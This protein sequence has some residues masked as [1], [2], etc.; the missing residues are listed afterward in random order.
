MQ[1][2]SLSAGTIVKVIVI[3]VLAWTLWLL[4]E[5]VL[6]VLASVVLASA[7]EPFARA[8]R[9]WRVAR[10]PAVIFIYLALA[11]VVV[12]IFYFFVPPLVSD[13]VELLSGLPLLVNSL[14][15]WSPFSTLSAPGAT[16]GLI[17]DGSVLRG[18]FAFGD[19]IQGL[20]IVSANVSEGFLPTLSVFFGGAISFVLIIVISFYLAVQEDGIAK[21]LRIVTPLRYEAYALGLWRRVQDKIGKWMQGQLLLAVLVGLL[22]Y[23]GLTVLGIENA[24]AFAFLAAVLETIPLFGP[25]IAAIPAVFAAYVAGGIPTGLLVV[26]LYVIIQQFENHLFYPLVVKKIVG[27]PP[28]LVILSLI[29]GA[30]L[31]GFLGLVLSVPIA[32]TLVEYLSD[33]QQAKLVARQ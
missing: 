10:V 26:G 25:I 7:V 20:Q 15:A 33:I 27:V 9:R 3:G 2:F 19:L 14:S 4:R 23:L 5:V 31:A 13:F 8:L 11:C 29:I 12:S 21:F 32:T 28:I 22:V 6:V 24:L 16:D 1:P 17:G 18:Q 30:K